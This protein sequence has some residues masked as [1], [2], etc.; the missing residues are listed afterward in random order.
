MVHLLSVHFG[1]NHETKVLCECNHL[2]S[3]A[4]LLITNVVCLMI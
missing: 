3:F 1:I 4:I 2:T